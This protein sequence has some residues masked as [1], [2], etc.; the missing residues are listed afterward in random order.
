MQIEKSK[1][2]ELKV[3]KHSLKKWQWKSL[4]TSAFGAADS[5]L[6]KIDSEALIRRP[7]KVRSRP[8]SLKPAKDRIAILRDVILRLE[9]SEDPALDPVMKAKL[10]RLLLEYITELD[11]GVSVEL[12]SKPSI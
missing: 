9:K 11:A 6:Q 7:E 2:P 8:M 10:G 5:L 3:S 1:G 12:Q 4:E